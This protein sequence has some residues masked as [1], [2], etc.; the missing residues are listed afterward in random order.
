MSETNYNDLVKKVAQL[1]RIDISES[2]VPEFA[3]N[4]QKIL[5][6]ID[7]LSTVNVEGVEPMSHV[8]GSV[9]VLREDKAQESLS[10][11]SLKA[12]APA[13]SGRFIK[14]PLIIDQNTEH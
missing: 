12:I 10:V 11:E 14:V 9:N 7:R 13:T 5:S 4:F 6:Y 1:A 8:H 3:K 2:E